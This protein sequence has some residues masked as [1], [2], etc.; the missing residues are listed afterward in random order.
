M[1]LKLAA[2]AIIPAFLIA[3]PPET[4][5][6]SGSKTTAHSSK[7]KSSSTQHMTAK[8][9]HK[10]NGRY[11]GKRKTAGWSF[12]AHPTTERYQQIQQALA[13]KGYFKGQ[14]DGKWGDDSVDAM[15]RFQAD[16]QMSN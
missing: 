12:Q 10:G 2:L 1:I 11:P 7:A 15:N 13:D 5:S 14:V 8:S 6:S 4:S 3:S 9:G 16:R